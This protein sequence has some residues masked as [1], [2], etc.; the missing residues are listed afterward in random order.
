MDTAIDAHMHG[1]EVRVIANAVA[2]ESAQRRRRALQLLTERGA[3]RIVHSPSIAR[4]ST[5]LIRVGINPG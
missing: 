1:L 3:A 2:A 5:P 4:A